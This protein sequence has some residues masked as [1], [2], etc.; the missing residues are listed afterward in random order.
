MNDG[1]PGAYHTGQTYPSVYTFGRKLVEQAQSDGADVVIFTTPHPNTNFMTDSMWVTPGTSSY[2]SNPPIPA[3]NK[4]GSTVQYVNADGTSV[5][6]SYRHVRV[7]ESLRR[8]AADTGAILLDAEKYW[9]KAVAKYGLGALFDTNEYAHPNLLGHQ[10]SY[11][12]AIDE[13]VNSLNTASLA[14]APKPVPYSPLVTYRVDATTRTS[15]TTLA[16][17]SQ[18]GVDVGAN[19]VWEVEIGAYYT[20]T[21]GDLRIG[22]ALPSGAS[23]RLGVTGFATNATG[24]ESG[25][26]THRSVALPDT[27]GLPV[28]GND[29]DA[30]ALARGI[31]RVGS[32]SGSIKPQWS[33]DTSSSSATTIYRDSYFKATRIA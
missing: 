29:A 13:F 15:S 2:P 3:D 28:G 22:L 23:G 19:Q 24:V 30:F 8:L 27:Y 17:D 5:P 10:Q 7:N 18:L 4:A 33:Q 32:T 21:T 16:A 11:W 12:L 26:S 9:F 6:A 1:M 14:A 20:G 25:P 31:V